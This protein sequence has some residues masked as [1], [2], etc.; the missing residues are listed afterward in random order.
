MAK[1]CFFITDEDFIQN[2][3]IG[4]HNEEIYNE[5]DSEL[6]EI[7]LNLLKENEYDNIFL[8]LCFGQTLSDFNGLRLATHIRCTP[9]KNQLK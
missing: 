5:S 6:T 3:I 7:V 4:A 8:P 9:T 1:L 2:A